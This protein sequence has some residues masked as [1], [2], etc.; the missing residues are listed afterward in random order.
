MP[1]NIFPRR[2]TDKEHAF[3]ATLS[4]IPDEDVDGLRHLALCCINDSEYSLRQNVNGDLIENWVNTATSL[5]ITKRKSLDAG[6][7]LAPDGE[8]RI[9]QIALA[10][11]CLLHTHPDPGQ[12]IEFGYLS[13]KTTTYLHPGQII[14]SRPTIY[15]FC[16]SD[17]YGL[18]VAQCSHGDIAPKAAV[19]GEIMPVRTKTEIILFMGN[20]SGHFRPEFESLTRAQTPAAEIFDTVAELP[21]RVQLCDGPVNQYAPRLAMKLTY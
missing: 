11:D 20:A 13:G 2:V 19:A 15:N 7:N 9:L 10:Y 12:T 17:Q 4:R 6:I 3:E 21:V 14:S 16:Y 5:F 8:Y 18:R 1:E